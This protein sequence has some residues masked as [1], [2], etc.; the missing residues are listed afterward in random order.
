MVSELIFLS[1]GIGTGIIIGYFV[2]KNKAYSDTDISTKSV[3]LQS[4]STQVTEM[5]GKFDEYEKLRDLKDNSKEK[6]DEEKEKRYKEFIEST[7]NFFDN[8]DS[9]R[10][11]YEEKRDSQMNTFASI[12]DAFNKTIH[13]TKT[14]GIVGE[15]I[16]RQYL[17]ESIK[18]KIIKTDLRMDSGD[19]EFA[20]N[21]GN[22]KYI[23]IDSKFPE[24]KKVNSE[25]DNIELEKSRKEIIDKSKTQI[26]RVK[27]YLNQNNT[28]N[29]CILAVPEEIIEIAPEIIDIGSRSNVIICSYKQVYLMA[30]ILSEE[31]EKLNQE[32]DLGK[33]KDTNKTLISIIKEIMLL[34]DTIERQAKSVMTHNDKIK[35][36]VKEGLRV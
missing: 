13:G 36:K 15:E 10:K 21:L 34:T 17:N 7:K 33:I 5:K 12:I 9:V 22:G 35:D 30:Y 25:S 29:K 4:L 1:V 3:L 32:G 24:F 23:P 14:R 26:K 2:G 28:I 27:K 19:V 11:N 20:W 8:Q 6:L 31:Y 16:L 18:S